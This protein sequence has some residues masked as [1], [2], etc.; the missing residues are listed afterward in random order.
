M[1]SGK[2]WVPDTFKLS[3]THRHDLNSLCTHVYPIKYS[4]YIS[5]IQHGTTYNPL[6]TT[7]NIIAN[8]Q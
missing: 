3:M 4:R 8:N 6:A 1:L 5:I 7:Q 2:H